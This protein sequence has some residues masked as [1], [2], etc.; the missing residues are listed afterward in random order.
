MKL[1]RGARMLCD[2]DWR[3]RAT[4]KRHKARKCLGGVCAECYLLAVSL[5]LYFSDLLWSLFHFL[6]F[7]K[8]CW[9]NILTQWPRKHFHWELDWKMEEFRG[10]INRVLVFQHFQSVKNLPAMQENQVRFLGREVPLVKGMAIS[11]LALKIPWTEEF[12]RLQLMGSQNRHDWVTN[13][14]SITI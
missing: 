4:V 12:G 10:R 2:R 3:F 8:S 11:T 1:E 9:K 7:P 13:T 14:I 5:L 6:S